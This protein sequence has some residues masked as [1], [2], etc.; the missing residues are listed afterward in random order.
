MQLPSDTDLAAAVDSADRR[1]EHVLK[2]DWARDGGY[3]HSLS[4]LTAVADEVTVERSYEGTLPQ[5]CTLVEGFSAAQLTAKLSG[6]RAGDARDIALMLAP[7]RPDSPLF[8]SGLPITPVTSDMTLRTGVGTAPTMRQFTGSVTE[9]GIDSAARTVD[10]KALDGAEQLRAAVTLPLFAQLK[11]YRFAEAWN[12]RFDVRINSQWIVD[13]V[14]RKNNIYISPPP[15]TGCIYSVSG[16]GSMLPDV[17]G[18]TYLFYPFGSITESTPLYRQGVFGLAINGSQDFA[19]VVLSMMSAPYYPATGRKYSYQF[20]V[21]WD[22]AGKLPPGATDGTVLVAY[23]GRTFPE[24]N[25]IAIGINT[26]GQLFFTVTNWVNG[27]QGNSNTVTFVS[28]LSVGWHSIGIELFYNGA[29]STVRSY[30]DGALGGTNAIDMTQWHS[31]SAF[32]AENGGVVLLGTRPIQCVQICDATGPTDGATF[33]NAATFTPQADVDAGLN[34]FNGTPDIAGADSWDVLKQVAAAEFATVGLT[35]TNRF[36]FRNRD[37]IRAQ[38]LTVEKTINASKAL[39]SLKVSEGAASIRNEISWPVAPRYISDNK[40]VYA[41]ASTSEIVA[42]GN[43]SIVLTVELPERALI[44]PGNMFQT[45][46]TNWNAADASHLHEFV[47]VNVETYVE[48]PNGSVFVLPWRVDDTHVRLRIINGNAYGVIFSTTDF[49]PAFSIGGNTFHTDS[50][51]SVTYQR[52]SSITKYGRR[53]DSIC[54]TAEVSGAGR[55]EPP[56]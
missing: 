22:G 38:N 20:Q 46:T 48:A 53:V 49:K 34:E 37:T 33:Y 18:P 19:Q 14:L 45:D 43:T 29:S 35:E 23:T 42:P 44:I 32:I 41:T 40:V 8:T 31:T 10:I 2:F 36:F 16:H 52:Q 15:Q 51:V 3:A 12:G 1:P 4:N 27:V 13:Y 54:A 28:T 11:S 50:T 39:K 55:A 25:Y 24:G 56:R 26:S 6:Q 21:Y 9:V 7:H 5:E 47:A 17:G 30:V